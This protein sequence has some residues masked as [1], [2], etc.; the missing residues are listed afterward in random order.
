VRCRLQSGPHCM[1][2]QEDRFLLRALH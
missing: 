1:K 2:T